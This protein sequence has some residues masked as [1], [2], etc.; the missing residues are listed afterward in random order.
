MVKRLNAIALYR[1]PISEL[2]SV[3][4]HMESHRVTILPATNT[5]ERAPP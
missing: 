5:G 3:T 4:R 1:K 2:Q